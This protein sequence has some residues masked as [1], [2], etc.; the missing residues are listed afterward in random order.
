M[1]VTALGQFPIHI[2]YI[3]LLLLLPQE[4][5]AFKPTHTINMELI[6]DTILFEY[7]Y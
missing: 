5:Q 3:F 2:L 6:Y 4:Q 7:K 1:I